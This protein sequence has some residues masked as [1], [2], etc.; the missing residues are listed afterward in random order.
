MS[1]TSSLTVHLDGRLFAMLA[2]RNTPPKGAYVSHGGMFYPVSAKT[3][4]P[5]SVV[6]ELAA[7]EPGRLVLLPADRGVLAL[8]SGSDRVVS[9]SRSD[10]DD[11]NQSF[12]RA[13]L[14]LTLLCANPQVVVV[15]KVP[16]LGAVDFKTVQ[17]KDLALPVVI[18]RS[19]SWQLMAIVAALI[20]AG[21]VIGITTKK[22]FNSELAAK[23]LAA[24]EAD[25]SMM[26]ALAQVKPGRQQIL[27]LSPAAAKPE[28]KEMIEGR[29]ARKAL[30]L[31]K[32]E[33]VVASVSNTSNASNTT[34]PVISYSFME[35]FLRGK[36]D[37]GPLPPG[38]HASG[39]TFTIP[40][41]PVAGQAIDSRNLTSA[42]FGNAAHVSGAVRITN[43]QLQ[44]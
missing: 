35:Q 4:Y 2:G 11:Q 20:S 34:L 29:A 23:T 8:I 19:R 31:D 9:I 28:S 3:G 33:Q 25:K 13:L 6:A 38:T 26:A 39:G 32:N 7:Q 21:V 36:V 17:L 5:L 30:G 22:S 42:A 16:D 10:I 27:A 37:G 41:P 18:R 14:R 43:G 44:F 40:A 1:P 24:E 12:F 15:G